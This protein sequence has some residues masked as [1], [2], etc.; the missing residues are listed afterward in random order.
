MGDSKPV[1][2]VFRGP[3]VDVNLHRKILR[4]F[5]AR[6]FRRSAGEG[7]SFRLKRERASPLGASSHPGSSSHPGRVSTFDSA[8]PRSKKCGI[9]GGIQSIHPMSGVHPYL[10][11]R[12]GQ[13]HLSAATAEWPEGGY[14][15]KGCECH[16]TMIMHRSGQA[17]HNALAGSAGKIDVSNRRSE[18]PRRVSPSE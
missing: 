12:D 7:R 8:A 3:R 15:Q 10:P 14:R 16:I 13:Q 4:E 17:L 1:E 6:R 18:W 11:R 9:L 2:T 5:Q